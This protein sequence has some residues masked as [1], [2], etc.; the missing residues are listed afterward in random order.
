MITYPY[1]YDIEFLKQ[2]DN[3]ASRTSYLK[4]LILDMED[5]VIETIEGR[6]TGGSLTV[7][8]SSAIRRSG[9]ISLVADKKINK[10]TDINNLISINK[11]ARI[12]VGI[13]NTLSKYKEYPILWFPQGTFVLTNA[14]VNNGGNG[15]SISATLKDKMALL[16]GEC[17]GTIYAAVTHTPI[18]H[19]LADG[20]FIEEKA[21]IVDLIRTLVH[22]WGKIPNDKIIIQDIPE[23]IQNTVSWGGKDSIYL[24]NE[25]IF[26]AEVVNAT[27]EILSTEIA[28]H[29]SAG[30]ILTDF[31]YPGELTSNP[32]ESVMQAL[33]KIKQSIGNYEYFFDLE[34]NFIF[35]KIQNYLDEGSAFDNLELAFGDAYLVSSNDQG[36]ATYS[37][38]DSPLLV[39]C[40]NSPKY[41]AIK[42]DYVVWGVKGDNK[43]AI[44]YHLVIDN[45]PIYETGE[46][47]VDCYT[48]SFGVFRIV[49]YNAPEDWKAN[50]EIMQET[51]IINDW[52]SYLYY[53]YVAN[54]NYNDYGKELQEEL[55]KIYNLKEGYYYAQATSDRDARTH[56][57]S[58]VYWLDILDPNQIDEPTV[59]NAL[60]QL[61]VS[62]IGRRTKTVKDDKINCL[63]NIAPLK[64]IFVPAEK[65]DTR[66]QRA[67]AIKWCNEKNEKIEN[68]E[69]WYVWTQVIN[70]FYDY[71]NIGAYTNPAYD[72]IRSVLHETT[73][74]NNAISLSVIP[75]YHLE[76]NTRIRVKNEEADIDGEF[77]INSI[78][79]PLDYKGT[80]NISASRAVERI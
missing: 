78:S 22:E 14:N 63:F 2:I 52:R 21:K 5:K 10:V 66:A 42:N 18:Y 19:Q 67:R 69:E 44:R 46:F 25:E 35:R 73:A 45:T 31:V 41:E 72:A 30:Y 13:K 57:N 24:Y 60:N 59:R 33:D 51:I 80:M 37:F 61:T 3:L 8:G 17:G 34:G 65:L 76:P 75:I 70:E 54:G 23:Y 43:V 6:A 38:V 62:A 56:L 71:F 79:I 1:L 48:D 16:N 49:P 64:W 20:S 39:S 40:S 36:K 9:S 50:Q 26:K 29:E 53:D 55:P 27:E 7:N 12:E 74:Y 58:M 28:Y 68:E 47:N 11:R 77:M 4:I 15:V 32:G